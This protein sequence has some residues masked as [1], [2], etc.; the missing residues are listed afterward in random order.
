M[1]SPSRRS[2]EEH[3]GKLPQPGVPSGPRNA[4]KPTVKV[5]VPYAPTAKGKAAEE[6]ARGPITVPYAPTPTGKAAERRAAAKPK[7]TVRPKSPEALLKPLRETHIPVSPQ[8]AYLN[9]KYHGIAPPASLKTNYSPKAFKK[10]EDARLKHISEHEGIHADPLAEFAIDTAATAGIGGIAAGVTKAAGEAG[11]EEA[12]NLLARGGSRIASKEATAGETAVEKGGAKI[13]AKIKAAPG[14]KLARV[15]TAPK[16][17]ATRVKETPERVRTAP[18]RAKKAA[19]TSE[20]R[21]AAAK[22][23]GKT[24]VHHPVRTGIP[25]AAALPPGVVPGSADPG[26][27]ARAF[28]EG[29]ADA[30]INHPGQVAETTG[31]GVLGFLTSPLAVAGAGVSSIKQG[32]PAPLVDTGKTLVKGTEKM[33]SNLASGDP[34]K[35]EQTTLKETGLTP[36]I[37]VPHALKRIKGSSAYEDSV[38]GKLRD[39]VEGK[40]ATT[41][42]KRIEAEKAATEEGRFVGKRKAKKVR[43]PVTDSARPQEK[44]V[45]RRTGK[46]IEKQRSRHGVSRD[47]ARMQESGDYAG[48]RAGKDVRGHLK[49]SKL[50]NQK[51]QNAGEALR[52]ISKYGIPQDERAGTAFVQALHDTYPKV[53]HG[54]IPP[55]V[56]L[57]RHSTQYILDHPELFHDKHFWNAVKAFEAQ[58]EDVGVSE[59]NRYLAS[60]N[61]IVNPRRKLEGKTP[62]LLPEERIPKEAFRYLPKRAESWNRK[63]A[64]DYLIAREEKVLNLRREAKAIQKKAKQNPRE[65]ADLKRTLR[66]ED[67]L[68][69]KLR[70]RLGFRER[71]ERQRQIKA[72]RRIYKGGPKKGLVRPRPAPLAQ[73]QKERSAL[74]DAEANVR[75]LHSEL[76]ERSG[77]RQTRMRSEVEQ[78]LQEARALETQQQGLHDSLRHL[79]KPPEHGGAEGGISTTRADAYTPEMLHDFTKEMKAE[80]SR[81]GLRTP[82]AYVADVVPSG[83]KGEDKAPNFAGNIPARKIWPSRGKAAAS[84][85]AESS[86][87]S[88]QHHSIEAPRMR[89]SVNK[90]LVEIFDKAQRKIDGKGVLT[91]AQVEQAINTHKVPD[92]TIFV[93]PQLI[94]GALEG[95]HALGP[96]AFHR[97]LDEE[98]GHGQKL[99]QS[100]GTELREELR[101]AEGVKGEKY[102]PADAAAIHELM[103]HMAPL[104]MVTKGAA[105]ASN[106][107]TRTILNSPAFAAI[108]IPQEGLPLAAA[109]AKNVVHIPKAIANL[110]KIAELPPEMLADYRAAVGSSVGVLGAPATKELRSEGFMDPIRAAGAYPKWRHAWN[111]VNGNTLG[112]FDRG[113]A[114]I[115]REVAADAKIHGDLKAAQKGFNVWRHGADNLFKGEEQAVKDMQGMSRAEQDAYVAAHPRLGDKL[116]RAMNDMAGNWNSFTVFEKHFAPLTIF[117]PFQ[118]YS[119]NWMLYHFP[120]DHPVV[121]TALTMLG[122]VNAQELQKIAATKGSTPDVLDYTMPV[123]QNG[124]GKQPTILPAGQRTFP[125]LSTVQQAVITG[126]PSQLVGELSPIAQIAVSAAQGI[127]SYTGEP[128][129]ESG[130]AYALR[131]LAS[132]SPAARL[133]GLN[134]LGDPKSPASQAFSKLDPLKSQRSTLDPFIGQ[135]A[136]QYAGTKQ[137]S[138]KFGEKYGAGKIP[139][140]FDSTLVQKLLY[141]NNGSPEPKLLPKVLDEI[142]KA[143]E[144][145][146]FVKGKEASSYGPEKPFSEVQSKLLEAVENAWET[147][148]NGKKK[149]KVRVTG[150]GGS[151][152]PIG[153]H[154]VGGGIGGSVGGSIGGGIGGHPVG[155]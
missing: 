128:L 126:K 105:H 7:A 38:R 87:E 67:R 93:R 47:V 63:E 118:R 124:E 65:L 55:G 102:M 73:M 151:S 16:R 81:L 64:L 75:G 40:R 71:A 45:L 114:G 150:I 135:T 138:R 134:E 13:L 31:H 62:V 32:S 61:S 110:K 51:E 116:V 146:S 99:A 66:R 23:A 19:S 121:A 143:E 101:D 58:S 132:L 91:R 131:Q 20:G 25:A 100:T 107:A 89:R 28:L 50:T 153:G 18:A 37:P 12:G 52:I 96:D 86:F 154:P 129:K 4:P 48:K 112:K 8:T 97:L 57:D 60:A 148:P 24:A 80:H 123:I 140:P 122:Q 9:A 56:H 145:S 141:G 88:L 125:G 1:A 83:L 59:R 115:F 98:V 70:E 109:L 42:A 36:F 113:R 127:D 144:A 130:W 106:F 136:S 76:R 147:G 26:K 69:T 152:G 39:T 111:L 133:A 6:K 22:G 85:N 14:N 68:A 92:G 17:A 82:A 119:I 94:K 33:V 104:G 54:D 78:R 155:G 11:A 10:A 53:E 90:G 43:Q 49:K 117:Y 46:L 3:E 15:R 72:G 34:K 137:L 44:Y 29:T 103:G 77:G 30:V 27:R 108:Q 21:R 35:V 41:R 5:S 142:H 74:L 120:L 2:R 149:P 84:G 139:G 95:E 79:M